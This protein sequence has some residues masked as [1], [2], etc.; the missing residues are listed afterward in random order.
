MIECN[1]T[2]LS[3]KY[4]TRDLD[5]LIAIKTPKTLI[6]NRITWLLLPNEDKSTEKTFNDDIIY[7]YKRLSVAID[8]SIEIG[9]V[10]LI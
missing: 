9:E 3:L 8:N 2:E 1:L 7:L 10:K 5:N 6:M 4:D